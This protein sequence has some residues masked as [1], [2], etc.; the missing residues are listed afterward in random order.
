MRGGHRSRLGDRFSARCPATP[1]RRTLGSGP[2]DQSTG[3]HCVA[4]AG[5]SLLAG[6]SPDRRP[7][8]GAPSDAG[9]QHPG[10]VLSPAPRPRRQMGRWS[11]VAGGDGSRGTRGLVFHRHAAA[12]SA[13]ALG[14]DPVRGLLGVLVGLLALVPAA[15]AHEVRPAYLQIKENTRG[16]YDVLWRTPV[17]SGMRL[18]VLLK[19]PEGVRNVTGPAVQELPDSL[20]ERRTIEAGEGGLAGRR[21]EFPGLQGT[22]T[23]VLVRVE[24]ADGGESTTLVTPSRPWVEIAVSQGMLAVM[25]AYVVHGIQHIAFGV[26]HLLFVLGL[27][28]IV[29]DRWTL[30][31]SVSA[32]T[33]AQ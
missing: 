27:L 5:T 21:I 19:L 2:G 10:D 1:R 7:A 18:P 28:L 24:M 3:R 22:I 20:L 14:S 25:G 13:C 8:S 29:E 23:D 30:V 4:R 6:T 16:R 17:L 26:D 15:R 31:K 33:V 9:L 32:F 11:A 12:D